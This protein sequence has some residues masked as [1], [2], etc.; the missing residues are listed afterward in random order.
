MSATFKPYYSIPFLG[1]TFHYRKITLGNSI[2][3]F[4]SVQ[5]LGKH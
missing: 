5:I 2:E 4:N 3:R 1:G